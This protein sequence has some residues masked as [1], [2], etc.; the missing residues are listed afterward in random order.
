MPPPDPHPPS[1]RPRSCATAFVLVAAAAFAAM[2]CQKQ[3]FPQDEPRSQYDRF[4]TVRDNRPPDKVP[5]AF[6]NNRPNLR[7]RLLR[8]E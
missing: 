2:G 8:T 4:D 5:D 3:L 1:S 6:G 7:G